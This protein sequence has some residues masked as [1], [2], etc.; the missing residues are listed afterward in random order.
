MPK[1]L[2]GTYRSRESALRA[3]E[4]LIDA[5]F[6]REEVCLLVPDDPGAHFTV[7]TVHETLAG[8][9]GGALIGLLVGALTGVLLAMAAITVPALDFIT[10]GPLMFALVGAGV[11]AAAGGLIGALIG[12]TRVHHETVV[13]SGHDSG[14]MLVGVTAPRNMAK[15]AEELLQI[16]GACKITRD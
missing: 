1:I 6:T 4:R 8:V 13:A 14:F 12:V 15:S 11:G 9:G 5:G 7:K 2:T 10:G 16:A 3:A